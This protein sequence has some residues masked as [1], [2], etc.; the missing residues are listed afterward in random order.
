MSNCRVPNCCL[1]T[2]VGLTVCWDHW[3]GLCL[4]RQSEPSLE[5]HIW[6]ERLSHTCGECEAVFWG[7]HYL[8]N[9]CRM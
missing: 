8:C 4:A 9:L 5:M 7:D 3:K 6:L 1:G 2:V